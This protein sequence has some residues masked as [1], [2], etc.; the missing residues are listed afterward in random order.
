MKHDLAP[1][2]HALC[3]NPLRAPEP[4]FLLVLS[5]AVA[6]QRCRQKQGDCR[7]EKGFP[8][9]KPLCCA[10]RGTSYRRRPRAPAVSA[11]FLERQ[12]RQMRSRIPHA[13]APVLQSPPFR[14]KSMN[15]CL[16][17]FALALLACFLAGAAAT[18]QQTE[19]DWSK[20][21]IKVS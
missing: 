20:V 8:A 11:T 18:A 7:R 2:G 5:A 1:L 10:H 19:P 17:A 4:L 21:Q 13:F 9:E 14:R 12:T 6:G 15:P 3:R 16:R